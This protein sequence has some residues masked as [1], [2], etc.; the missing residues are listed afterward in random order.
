MP[1]LSQSAASHVCRLGGPRILWPLWYWYQNQNQ[2]SNPVAVIC[3]KL[4]V[5]LVS[6]ETKTASAYGILGPSIPKPRAMLC[7]DYAGCHWAM[8]PIAGNSKSHGSRPDVKLS[9][10]G[11]NFTSC[12]WPLLEPM[13]LPL[14]LSWLRMPGR[15]ATPTSNWLRMRRGDGTQEK[16]RLQ[17]SHASFSPSPSSHPSTLSSHSLLEHPLPWRPADPSQATATTWCYYQPAA[18]IPKTADK[19]VLVKLVPVSGLA[20]SCSIGRHGIS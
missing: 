1:V 13:A 5:T 14:Q 19:V 4:W 3:C 11:A 17:R 6:P 2:K 8:R 16:P 9:D 15:L 7:T 10:H 12:R 20:D 18:T